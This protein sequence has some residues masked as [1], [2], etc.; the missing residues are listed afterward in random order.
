MITT[1]ISIATKN[2]KPQTPASVRANREIITKQQTKIGIC[3]YGFVGK[4]LDN[5][6]KHFGMQTTAIYDPYIFK[7]V[8]PTDLLPCDMIFV[9]VPTPMSKDGSMD[10]SIINEVLNNLV[11]IKYTGTVIIKSTVTPLHIREIVNKY[12]TLTIIANPEFL[13]ERTADKDFIN[14]KW[15]IIGGKPE[16]TKNLA[17]LSRRLWPTAEIVE[18][19]IEA[20]MMMKYM[21]NSW[22]AV[23]VSLLNEFYKLYS[24][25]GCKDW[26]DLMKAFA[27]DT[28]VGPSHL[29]VPGPDGD[30]GWG[31]KCFPK[32][33]NAIMSL[34]RNFKTLDNVLRAAWDTNKEV[35]TNMDWLK[36][37]GAV[38]EDYAK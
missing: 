16:Q 26:D 35:R 33:L 38:S 22:Y 9:C 5:G 34:T 24:A 15:V 27:A 36:I 13:T 14:S 31:G 18:V 12:N 32:D 20:A 37:T 17:D 28:R 21:T 6:L 29:K 8:K 11:T 2:L 7:D 3:G 19:S 25:L 30:F 10:V 1:Q 23:K 4:A